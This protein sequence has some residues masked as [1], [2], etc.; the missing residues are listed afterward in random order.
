[1]KNWQGLTGF[2]LSLLSLVC[3]FVGVQSIFYR[4]LLILAPIFG[5]IGLIFCLIQLKKGKTILSIIGLIINIIVIV[6]SGF[7][8]YNIISRPV[9]TTPPC[10]TY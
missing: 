9:C 3:L 10:P 5:V 1:M 4:I 7:Q 2:I 6:L 8:L